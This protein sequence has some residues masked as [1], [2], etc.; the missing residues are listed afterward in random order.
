MNERRLREVF[1]FDPETGVFTRLVSVSNIK[2]GYSTPGSPAK[3]G[4]LR[5][6]IDGRLYYS[7]RLAWLW[8]YGSWPNKNIDHIDGNPRNNAISNLRLADQSENLQNISKSSKAQSGL[9]GAYLERS[10]G[11]WCSKIMID[12]KSIHLGTFETP[13]AA[14]AAYIDAKKRIHTFHGELTR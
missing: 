12:K 6:R 3:N 5:L 2:A 9:R 11:R 1:D 8:V 7:H 13:E 10:T 14:H 4:Y